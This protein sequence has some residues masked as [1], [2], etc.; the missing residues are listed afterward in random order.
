MNKKLKDCHV[1]V[2]PTSFGRDDAELINYL[3][4]RVGRVTYNQTGEPLPVKSLLEML[5]GVDGYIA[6]LDVINRQVLEES[7][8]LQVIARYGVGVDNVDL[9]T[10]A[11]K[12]IT[13]TN[14][15]GANSASVAE[16]A[17]MLILASARPVIQ[18]AS[19]AKS[20]AW[21]RFKG[22]SLEGKTVG[23]I[24]LGDIGKATAVRL[25]NFNCQVLAFDIDPDEVFASSYG[26]DLL[27]L[28]EVAARS[29]FLSLHC[30]LLPATMGMVNQEFI[31][32]MKTGAVLINTARGE[33]VDEAALLQALDAGKLSGAALDVF[34]KQPPDPDNPLLVH[35]RVIVTP[36]MAAHTDGATHNMGWGAVKN[37]LAVLEGQEP[38]NRV[39]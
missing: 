12:D 18:A 28:N 35:P 19:A 15:P 7:G 39:I 33:L 11:E 2:T 24:G 27:S 17:V 14:T 23:L 13:V 10:A 5:P 32:S 20:G 21:P 1:L 8:Q 36:H 31:S 6:G 30:S 22:I 16:L 29:D 34:V 4:S 9:D 38:P 26:L 37:C 3:E 25:V